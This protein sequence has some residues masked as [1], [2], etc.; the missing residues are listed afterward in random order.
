[1]LVGCGSEPESTGE[2][3]GEPV[4]VEIFGVALEVVQDR[5]EAV[6]T[7]RPRTSAKLASQVMATIESV[8][9]EPGDAVEAGQ[10]L[11]ALD[12]RDLRA[13]YDRARADYERFRRL[14]E[15][16]AVTQAE[17]DVVESR[18][19]VAR[20]A[21]SYSEIRAPFAGV[22]VQKLCDAGDM[23]VPGKTLFEI[24]AANAFRVEALIPERYGRFA[25]V[26]AATEVRVD[27]SGERC[28]GSIGEVVPGAQAETRSILVKIDAACGGP[29]QSGGFARARLP[30][31][32]RSVISV[33]PA[34]LRRTGQL[35][36]V[37][38]VHDGRAAMRLVKPGPARD[39]RVEVL[40]GLEPG[41]RV[42]VR[43]EREISDGQP[44]RERAQSGSG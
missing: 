1:L 14:L 16:N 44:I 20:A 8:A 9:V 25:L 15:K 19:R 33:P 4:L 13:E 39:E 42:I 22:V 41:D 36:Y 7:I 37:Y 12:D 27:A 5:Y 24:E 28:S 35:E 6:G 11:A 3:R 31:G 26:G 29:L 43:A 40:S 21:L 23:A 32:E 2:P 17:L 18:F 30:V 10:Q 34:A 38:V